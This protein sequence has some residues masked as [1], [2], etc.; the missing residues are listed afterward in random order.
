MSEDSTKCRVYNLEVIEKEKEKTQY[1]VMNASRNKINFDL[2]MGGLICDEYN[3]KIVV[4]FREQ[5][6]RDISELNFDA[7][8]E[9]WY[10][11]H[12]SK[13]QELIGLVTKFVKGQRI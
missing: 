10:R 7:D 12:N 4:D 1:C 3:G 13:L 8:I 11:K 2:C 6:I 9:S 5:S